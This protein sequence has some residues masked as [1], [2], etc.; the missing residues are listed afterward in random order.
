[1]TIT[2]LLLLGVIAV[3]LMQLGVSVYLLQ[4]KEVLPSVPAM[5]LTS[6]PVPLP[7]SVRQEIRERLQ[8]RVVQPGSGRELLRQRLAQRAAEQKL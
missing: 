5:P 4:Q 1:M 2:D 7:E 6:T 8:Q 3:N